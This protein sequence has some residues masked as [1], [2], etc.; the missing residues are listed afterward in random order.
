MNEC[1]HVIV[2]DVCCTIKRP[3]TMCLA[4]KEKRVWPDCGWLCWI[5]NAVA[6]TRQS[7]EPPPR[8][9]QPRKRLSSA[10][11]GENPNRRWT[12]SPRRR[13][14]L[15][16]TVYLAVAAVCNDCLH[17]PVTS[18]T[19]CNQPQLFIGERCT[20]GY[21]VNSSLVLVSRRREQSVA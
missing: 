6:S 19:V 10:G 16:E 8:G 7:T 17:R 15:G 2:A 12:E 11:T 18:T 21:S 3:T 4:K 1:E 5:N 20:P 14:L 9:G 13:R